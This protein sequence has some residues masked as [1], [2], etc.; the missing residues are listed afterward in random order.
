MQNQIKQAYIPFWDWEDYKAGMWRKLPKS[1]ELDMLNKCIKFTGN[2][3]KYGD[4][5]RVVVDKWHKTM[6]KNHQKQQKFDKKL[7]NR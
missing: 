5:M 6:L 2:H 4:A 7:P 3:V 1:Q